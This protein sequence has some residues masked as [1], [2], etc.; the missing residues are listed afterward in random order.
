MGQRTLTFIVLFSLG[1]IG[2]SLYL[3]SMLDP[4]EKPRPTTE[5]ININ[6]KDL[7]V[8]DD[9]KLKF[10]DGTEFNHTN[11]EGKFTVLYFGFASCPDVCPTVLDTLSQV[12]KKLDEKE[13]EKIQFVFISIDPER[14]SLENVKHFVSNFAHINGAT[15]DRYELDKLASSLMAYYVKN[16]P[17][18]GNDENDYYVD[19]SSFVYLLDPKV[20]LLTQF[21]PKVSSE[22]LLDVIKAKIATHK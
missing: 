6:N 18:K 21:T 17:I 12:A 1:L 4:A 9:F 15:G 8:S 22:E 3:I 10:I 16:K 2:V 20:S 7:H 13:L 19:H 11:L 14:D 5:I